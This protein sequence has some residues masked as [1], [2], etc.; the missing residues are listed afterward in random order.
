MENSTQTKFN[1]VDEYIAA[2][3]ENARL[4]LQTIRNV[5]RQVAPGA[6]ELI[7]Y[8]MPA[9]KTGRILAYYAAHKAHIGFYPASV[10]VINAFGNQLTA[11]KTSKGA[12]QFPFEKGIPEALVES[13]IRYRLIENDLKLKTKKK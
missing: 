3:P 2:Q 7:S 12:I 5:I 8:N 1:S 11:Y 6:T 10:A 4:L 13:I 9:F